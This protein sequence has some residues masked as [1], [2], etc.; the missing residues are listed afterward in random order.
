MYKV[1]LSMSVALLMLAGCSSEKADTQIEQQ[2]GDLI[3]IETFDG[4]NLVSQAI[5]LDELQSTYG[6][7]S[8]VETRANDNSVH[9]HGEVHAYG[10]NTFSFSGTQNNGGTHG[11]AEIDYTSNFTGENAHVI[12]ET[13]TVIAANIGGKDAAVYGGTIT[14]VIENTFAPGSNSCENWGLGQ[15]VWFAVLDNGE[16]INAPAD[17][18]RSVFLRSCIDLTNQG[19]GVANFFNFFFFSWNDVE[20]ESDHIKVNY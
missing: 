19:V 20:E 16:G 3:Y 1:I 18:I 7:S 11:S 5:S 10:G 6:N 14:E 4:D 17:Q 9:T 2:T 12:L 8:A 13:L 15:N